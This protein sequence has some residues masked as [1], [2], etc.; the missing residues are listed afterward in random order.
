MTQKQKEHLHIHIKIV[1][2]LLIAAAVSITYPASV[3]QTHKRLKLAYDPETI[4]EVII[5]ED[6]EESL[7]ND[8][9]II[10]ATNE[11]ALLDIQEDNI[12][13]QNL[14]DTQGSEVL[15]LQAQREQLQVYLDGVNSK[16]DKVKQYAEV[17]T[18]SSIWTTVL[19]L[20]VTAVLAFL[21]L[22]AE[23]HLKKINHQYRKL[24]R[25]VDHYESVGH[26]KGSKKRVMTVRPIRKKKT[27]TK[28]SPA[29]RK[30]PITKKPTTKKPAKKRPTTRKQ[31]KKKSTGTKK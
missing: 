16:Y 4:K 26:S 21:V 23:I 25:R 20:L 24:E 8:R 14:S 1:T 31:S 27:S 18:K 29:G 30:K 22:R 19:L 15:G 12:P 2:V 9:P 17:S 10:A 6:I 28:K 7:N 3:E 13:I 5:E 11:N